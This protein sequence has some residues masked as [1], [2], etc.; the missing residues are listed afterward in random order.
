MIQKHDIAGVLKVASK[1]ALIFLTPKP[2][3]INLELQIKTF[4]QKALDFSIF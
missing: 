4:H 1:D 3:T 2:A